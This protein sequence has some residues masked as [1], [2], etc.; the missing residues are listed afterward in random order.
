METG[1]KIIVLIVIAGIVFGIVYLYKGISFIPSPTSSPSE[2]LQNATIAKSNTKKGT[3]L[4]L[5]VLIGA[6]I[7]KKAMKKA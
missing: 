5:F 3:A 4:I 1:D 2:N 6:V 7:A